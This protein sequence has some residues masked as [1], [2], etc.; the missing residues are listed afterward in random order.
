MVSEVQLLTFVFL[1]TFL[2]PCTRDQC[3]LT[4]VHIHT[5]TKTQTPKHTHTN[6]YTLHMANVAYP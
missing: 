2:L 5:H 3:K 4:F 1:I 6:I